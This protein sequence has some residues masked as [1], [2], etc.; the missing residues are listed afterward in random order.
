MKLKEVKFEE[1]VLS[2][3]LVYSCNY[4]SRSFKFLHYLRKHIARLH[5][6]RSFQCHV[7]PKVILR[8]DNFESHKLKHNPEAP[9]VC[10]SCQKHFKTSVALAKH[11]VSGEYCP[12]Q[13]ILCTKTFDKKTNL[14]K[15]QK[16]CNGHLNDFNG[17][18]EICLKKFQYK[19]D[20]DIERAS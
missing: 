12:L 15:H 11:L 4:C 17:T 3:K 1:R 14:E 13:C 8:K 20:I 5:I 2:R 16:I 18:C 9:N 6:K 7:C 19:I 10:L